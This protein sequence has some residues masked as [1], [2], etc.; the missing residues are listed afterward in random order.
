MLERHASQRS[1]DVSQELTLEAARAFADEVLFPNANEVDA[2]PVVPPAR[3]D[4]LADHG[5]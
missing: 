3:L 1:I 2:L 5:W 4:L